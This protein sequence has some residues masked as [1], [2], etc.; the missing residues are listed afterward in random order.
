[1]PPSSDLLPRSHPRS[2]QPAPQPLRRDATHE[3]ARSGPALF[4][5]SWQ[6]AA[7]QRNAADRTLLYVVAVALSLVGG[8]VMRTLVW[9]GGDNSSLAGAAVFT[10]L[11]MALAPTI[12]MV[13]V[14]ALITAVMY[15]VLLRSWWSL[16]AAPAAFVAGILLWHVGDVGIQAAVAAVAA[17]GRS[18]DYWGQVLAGEIWGEMWQVVWRCAA[19]AVLGAVLGTALGRWTTAP[20]ARRTSGA[21]DDA[22]HPSYPRHATVQ[23]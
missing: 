14:G 20:Q 23:R 2:R 10:R 1:M 12:S 21:G 22:Q 19:P 3:L 13:A 4:P 7:R 5:A 9:S 16:L 17:S 18:W 15:G 8:L 11:E 6:R